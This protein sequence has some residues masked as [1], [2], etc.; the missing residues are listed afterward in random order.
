MR[1]RKFKR[2]ALVDPSG[3]CL[4]YPDEYLYELSNYAILCFFHERGKNYWDG[5]DLILPKGT[6]NY[7]YVVYTVTYR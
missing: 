1:K 5:Q 4:F 6:T 3:N 2:V 7:R